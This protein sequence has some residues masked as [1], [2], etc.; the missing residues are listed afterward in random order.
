M[1]EYQTYLAS[2][3][4]EEQKMSFRTDNTDGLLRWLGYETEEPG[5]AE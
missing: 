3:E 2:D 4:R 5:Y 1:E